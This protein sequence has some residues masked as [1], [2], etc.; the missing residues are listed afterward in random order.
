MKK[1]LTPERLIMVLFVGIIAT[2]IYLQGAQKGIR[3]IDPSTLAK[4]VKQEPDTVIVIDVRTL[5]EHEAGYIPGT[6][7]NIDYNELDAHI[8]KLPSDK[9]ARIVVYC[10]SGRRSAMA[11]KT[12]EEMG[13]TNLYNLDGGVLR[14]TREGYPLEKDK[15]NDGSKERS[16]LFFRHNVRRPVVPLS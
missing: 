10:R 5:E 1:I 13:Y 14:W 9:N 3:S 15:E 4:W 12:L 8:D 16:F 7:L 6:D 11:Y 2:G